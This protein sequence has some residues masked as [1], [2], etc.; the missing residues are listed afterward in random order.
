M[1]KFAL[2]LFKAF[3]SACSIKLPVHAQRVYPPSLTTP[4]TPDRSVYT[5]HK[6]PKVIPTSA[7]NLRKMPSALARQGV[8]FSRRFRKNGGKNLK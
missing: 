7:R 5:L 4:N 6:I 8:I 3:R 2:T 1:Q